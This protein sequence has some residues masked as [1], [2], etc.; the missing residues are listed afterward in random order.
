V[1]EHT[2]A[3]VQR[4]QVAQRMFIGRLKLMVLS[5][6]EKPQNGNRHLLL[7]ST[8]PINANRAKEVPVQAHARCAPMWHTLL[9]RVLPKL[10]KFVT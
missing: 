1:P 9:A 6:R 2:H 4:Q 10:Q 8:A 5:L 3:S 7:C